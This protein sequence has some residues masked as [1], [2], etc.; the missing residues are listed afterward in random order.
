MAVKSSGAVLEVRLQELTQLVIEGYG[1]QEIEN[2]CKKK[3]NITSNTTIERYMKAIKERLQKS[4]EVD[5]AYNRSVQV[6]RYSNI[7]KQLFPLLFKTKEIV[8]KETEKKKNKVFLNA[9]AIR[10]YLMTC[11]RLDRIQ[12][13]ESVTHKFEGLLN[14]MNVDVELKPEDEAAYEDTLRN[15]FSGGNKKA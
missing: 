14:H 8:D 12:G 15:I 11:R 10:L 7:L 1:W 9:R 13:T 6:S 5:L 4:G 3:W 2:H